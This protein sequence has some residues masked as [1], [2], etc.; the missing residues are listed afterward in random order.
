M[1]SCTV[2]LDYED[3]DGKSY[4]HSIDLDVKEFQKLVRIGSS[5][6]RKQLTALESIDDSVSTFVDKV[7]GEDKSEVA[8]SLG[9]IQKAMKGE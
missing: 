7:T 3:L 8:K 6:A 1:E 4:G 9:L 2:Q 5:V